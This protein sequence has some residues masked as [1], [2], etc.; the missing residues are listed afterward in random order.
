M[1]ILQNSILHFTMPYIEVYIYR[2]NRYHFRCTIQN[3]YDTINSCWTVKGKTFK[4]PVT[5][6]E[7]LFTNPYTFHSRTQSIHFLPLGTHTCNFLFR[8]ERVNVVE[9]LLL[10]L[11]T[12]TMINTL[13]GIYGG[14]VISV[15]IMTLDML[16]DSA[17]E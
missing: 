16:M 13:S 15:Q 5:Q 8:Q 1:A 4:E 14:A 9:K 12:N 7:F 11:S 6:I 17:L 2:I 10:V 3:L